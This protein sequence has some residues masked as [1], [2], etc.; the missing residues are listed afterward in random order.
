MNELIVQEVELIEANPDCSPVFLD[1]CKITVSIRHLA[2]R[3][4][5]PGHL[6]KYVDE[7]QQLSESFAHQNE[8]LPT[9]VPEL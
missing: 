6:V 7:N 5:I 2:T 9:G 8:K 3:R 1:A 4:D